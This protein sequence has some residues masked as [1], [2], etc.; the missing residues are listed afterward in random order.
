VESR[1]IQTTLDGESFYVL[2]SVNVAT[3]LVA[4]PV[5]LYGARQYRFHQAVEKLVLACEMS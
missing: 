1:S 4:K 5:C 2:V 3:G